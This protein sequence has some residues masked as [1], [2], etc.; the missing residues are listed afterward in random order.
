MSAVTESPFPIPR[1]VAMILAGVGCVAVGGILAAR[2][3]DATPMIA[4]PAI[5]FGV[6]AITGPALYIAT[7]AAGNAPSL[8]AVVR[9]FGVALGAFGIALAGLILPAAFL[10]MSSVTNAMTIVTATGAIA[11]AA[12]LGLRR[13]ASELQIR[14]ARAGG[15]VFFGWAVATAGIAG[16]L[17]WDLAVA[18]VS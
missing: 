14:P 18:V 17:W 11:G 2:A 1:N 10:A 16:R 13:L 12:F 8:T 6:V 9:A 4:A 15:L 7:A 5:V 3:G